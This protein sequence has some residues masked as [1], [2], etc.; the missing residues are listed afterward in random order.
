MLVWILE[1]VMSVHAAVK[2]WAQL[3]LR[4]CVRTLMPAAYH[5]LPPLIACGVVQQAVQEG[6]PEGWTLL[7]SLHLL[8]VDEEVLTTTQRGCKFE[9]DMLV[10]NKLGVAVAIVEGKHILFL[11]KCVDFLPCF[12]APNG[13]I[14]APFLIWPA[15]IDCIV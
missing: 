5:V 4:P 8:G 15:R 3:P 12:T 2:R 7:S 10:L 6:L 9:A 1:V 13:S 14:S 11:D